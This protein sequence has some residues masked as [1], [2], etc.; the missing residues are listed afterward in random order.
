MTLD[1]TMLIPRHA[2][3]FH[4]GSPDGP[5]HRAIDVAAAWHMSALRELREANGRVRDLTEQHTQARRTAERALAEMAAAEGALRT[6][7]AADDVP[8]LTL[9]SYRTDDDP[10]PSQPGE[11]AA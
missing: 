1:P 8:G 7:A 3:L 5:S 6:I 11:G 9:S 4:T 10:A 2:F